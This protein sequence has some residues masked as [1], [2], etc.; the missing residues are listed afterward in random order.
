MRGSILDPRIDGMHGRR[1]SGFAGI[2]S[3]VGR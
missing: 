2:L 3:A 1:E